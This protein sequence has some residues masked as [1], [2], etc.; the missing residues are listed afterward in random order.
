MPGP[1]RARG[2][3]AI[4]GGYDSVRLTPHFFAI[5]PTPA[6][7]QWPWA[8]VLGVPPQQVIG[9]TLPRFPPPSNGASD[10]LT[11]T[12]AAALRSS[13]N[14]LSPES[15]EGLHGSSPHEVFSLRG[16]GLRGSGPLLNPL[17]AQAVDG[18]W[19]GRRGWGLK[20]LRLPPRRGTVLPALPCC[21][22]GPWALGGCSARRPGFAPDWQLTKEKRGGAQTEGPAL[23]GAGRGRRFW[24]PA[25][26]S[27]F[28]RSL[29]KGRG[30]ARRTPRLKE[31]PVGLGPQS[32]SY[33]SSSPLNPS[34]SGWP[35]LLP[36]HHL[37]L[38]L[39]DFTFVSHLQLLD[40]GTRS[41]SPL[42]P[43]T[44]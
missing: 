35:G 24:R 9:P 10:S 2:P 37:H 14:S 7:C 5:L 20:E 11:L 8:G 44:E 21:D 27:P 19:G 17:C 15:V 41:C 33:H 28:T 34:P 3:A 39:P 43:D 36:P 13:R 31:H 32:R 26:V 30:W 23:R 1:P 38:P 40:G 6:S 4:T 29:P 12:G 42:P 25:A 16:W 22:T 18:V